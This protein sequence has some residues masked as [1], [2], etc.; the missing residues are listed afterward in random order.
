MPKR[1]IAIF[2]SGSGSNFQNIVEYFMGDLHIEVAHLFCNNPNAFSI[3][4]AQNL[5]VE[6]TI[7][8]KDDFYQ[9]NVVLAKLEDLKIDFI[10]LAGFLWLVP[11]SLVAKFP[12]KIINIHPAL[13]PKYGGKG[14]YGHF[15]HEAVASNK[16]KESGIT[17]HWVNEHYDEGNIIFQTKTQIL[18]T[19]TANEIARK[20]HLLEAEHFPRIV[21]ET[22]YSSFG[23]K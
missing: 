14:M 9:S 21:K 15:V 7:F 23:I 17:I 11:S 5:G 13:L 8:N 18:P 3:Q 16:E 20:I 22:I 1:R 2:A 4:R 10:V 19:D 6:F 12:S